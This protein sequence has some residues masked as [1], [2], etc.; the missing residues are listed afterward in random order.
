MTSEILWSIFVFVVTFEFVSHILQ[1][2]WV[3][4]NKYN[5][6]KKDNLETGRALDHFKFCV[7]LL[8][9]SKNEVAFSGM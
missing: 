3:R 6:K 5:D 2:S 9:V 1:R 7:E 8:T 4:Q